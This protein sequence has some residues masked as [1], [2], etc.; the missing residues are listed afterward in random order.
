MTDDTPN[1]GCSTIRSSKSETEVSIKG[2]DVATAYR[3]TA[4]LNAREE[5]VDVGCIGSNVE[6]DSQR[7]HTMRVSSEKV[8]RFG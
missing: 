7:K 4:K 5:G 2:N 3:N 6:A 1:G 8:L